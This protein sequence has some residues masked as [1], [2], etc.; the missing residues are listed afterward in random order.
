MLI[1]TYDANSRCRSKLILTG[2]RVSLIISFF[3]NVLVVGSHFLR[4]FIWKS[5]DRLVERGLKGG[6][7]DDLSNNNGL[8]AIE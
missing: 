7:S 5:C 4:T 6:V 2:W 8:S 1:P 3:G